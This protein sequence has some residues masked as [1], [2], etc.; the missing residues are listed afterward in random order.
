MGTPGTHSAAAQPER[1]AAVPTR[2]QPCRWPEPR[3]VRQSLAR[4]AASGRLEA[5]QR[6]RSWR[7]GCVARPIA[8]CA[9]RVLATFAGA[10]RRRGAGRP[11]LRAAAAPAEAA[12][13]GAHVYPG[14]GMIGFGSVD[15]AAPATART[16]QLARSSPAPPPPTAAGT[17]WPAPT[18]GSS[19]S[20]TPPS[21]ARSATC[22]CRA[23][24]SPWRPRPTAKG[25]W[26]GALDGGV[27]AFGDAQF[28]GSHGRDPAQPAHRGHGGDAR[29]Q[30]VLAGGRRRGDLHLRRRRVL[31]QHGRHRRSTQP[32]VGMAATPDGKGYWLV[33]ADGGIFTFGDARLLRVAGQPTT[34]PTRWWAWSPPPTA[35][36][37]PWPPPTA[38]CC[39][40]ATP[41]AYGGL[42]LD[43]DGHP[44]LGHHRQRGQGN[45]YWLLDPRPGATASPRPRPSR[46][47]PGRPPSWPPWRR[48]SSPIP[49]PAGVVQPLRAVR[50]VVRAVR[51]LGLGAGGHTDPVATP[52]WGTSR[53]GRRPRRR[54]PA[55][56]HPGLGDAVLYGTGPQSVDTSVHVG[57]VTQVWPDGAI[58]T[59]DGD[60][61]P[62]RERLALGGHQRALPAGRLAVVQRRADLRLRA[63][64][65]APGLASL[66]PARRPARRAARRGG[67]R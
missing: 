1:P 49:T 20:A 43:P 16:A 12:A 7:V 63:A 19:P 36:A 67:R 52:S 54:A 24:S 25:Y 45:G 60:S 34:S 26:L 18:A 30:G 38:W 17:G 9:C 3:R 4:C 46:S 53:L 33:A 66:P 14:G 31:R 28:Y 42:T 65:E 22:R 57:I 2:D 48:R 58:E 6:R 47:S 59:V 44:D 13:V 64:L 37:T 56:G 5:C 61:G 39:P 11:S 55:D 62:G 10:P 27:F 23:R 29:R 8:P 51:H 41:S 35:G 15:L 40:S 32:I 21:R 50:G